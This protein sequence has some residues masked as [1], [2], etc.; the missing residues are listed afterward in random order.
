MEASEQVDHI[1][2]PKTS[3]MNL[4][5]ILQLGNVNTASE[6]LNSSS[7]VPHSYIHAA[8]FTYLTSNTFITT[9]LLLI[10][11]LTTKCITNKNE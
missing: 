9:I 3:E 2:K 7:F 11:S 5:S 6:F 10:A 4:L 1:L 8:F